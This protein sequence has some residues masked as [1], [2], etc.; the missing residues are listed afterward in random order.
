MKA[1]ERQTE[2]RESQERDAVLITSSVAM[3]CKSQNSRGSFVVR[4]TR[5]GADKFRP[6]DNKSVR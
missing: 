5:H 1:V 2:Q 4:V 6:R 3:C